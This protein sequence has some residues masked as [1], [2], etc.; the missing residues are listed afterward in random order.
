MCQLVSVLYVMSSVEALPI[1][2]M[3]VQSKN[4]AGL[5]TC[6]STGYEL[7]RYTLEAP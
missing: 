5:I 4:S 3:F 2:H 7:I 1:M 6:D